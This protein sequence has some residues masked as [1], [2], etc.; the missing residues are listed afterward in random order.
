MTKRKRGF[1]IILI[2]GALFLISARGEAGDVQFN[3]DIRPILSETCYKCHGPD[4][5]SR[6]ADLRFDRREVAVSVGAINPGKPDKS[7]MIERIYSDDPDQQ[8]PPPSSHKSLTTSQKDLLKKWI[9]EGAEYQPLWS[10]IA[11][12]RPELPAVKNAAWVKN[13]VDRFILA[14]LEASGLEPAA[15]AGRRTLAR[16]VSLDLT[17]LPPSSEDVEHYVTDQSP[18]AYEK[19][20]DRLLASPRWGEHRA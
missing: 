4:S 10:F 15:E 16:R 7:E 14:R 17:G 20:V 13:P 19:Y 8:M 9:A 1:S 12:K 11:P 2:T 18:D 3:R 5:A 6:K